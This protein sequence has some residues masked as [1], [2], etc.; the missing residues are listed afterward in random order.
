MMRGIQP[1]KIIV[2]PLDALIHLCCLI[3]FT[4]AAVHRFGW[5]DG[6]LMISALT[7]LGPG[8][9]KVPAPEKESEGV[10]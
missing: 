10:K 1:F 5:L 7:L 6:G 3:F 8:L 2:H 9:Q 4:I